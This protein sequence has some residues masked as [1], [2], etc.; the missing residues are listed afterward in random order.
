MDEPVVV[1]LA[2]PLRGAPAERVAAVSPRIRIAWVTPAG[3]PRDDVSQVEVVYR[4]GGL[5]PA[6]L[7]RLLPQMPR[8][9]WIHAMGAGVDGDLTPEVVRSDVIVTRTRGL[10]LIPVSEWV[11]LL[12]LAA[13][14]RFPELV[15]AQQRHEWRKVPVPVSLVGRTI[16]IVGYGEIGQAIAARARGFGFRLIGVRRRPRPAPELD[17][18]YPVDQ[19]QRLLAESDY[20]VLTTPLTPET[21]GMIGA[22]ELRAMQPTAWL[23]NVGRGE[24]VQEAALLQALHEGWIAGAALDVFSQEPLPPDHPLWSA[25][26]VIITPHSG[27]VAHPAFAEETLQQF[28]DNLARYVRGEPLRNVVDKLAGY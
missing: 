7:R 23:I 26:N 10:H 22:A 2:E 13:S 19:L 6:G 18:L 28:V 15:L 3:E 20:V 17:A 27:G 12:I 1:A 11:M 8:L 24:V 16:G 21:R 5:M 14:K 9:R 25:P 4:G